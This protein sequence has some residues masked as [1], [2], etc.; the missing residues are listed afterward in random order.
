MTHKANF[1]IA[2][3]KLRLARGLTQEDFSLVSSRT[4][5]SALERGIKSP[6]LEKVLIL[7]QTLD[8]S[9]IILIALAFTP[10]ADI[11]KTIKMLDVIKAELESLE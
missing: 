11:K 2:L 1:G 8:I 5:I 4:Y 10:D 7:A 9:P 3:K 6:T